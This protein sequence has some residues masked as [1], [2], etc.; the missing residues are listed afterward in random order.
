MQERTRA[1]CPRSKKRRGSKRDADPSPVP[2]QAI[3]SSLFPS[4]PSSFF[5][6]PGN[7]YTVARHTT[8]R[9]T[10]H[11]QYHQEH[12]QEKNR[13][14][15]RT[16]KRADTIVR[17][18][19]VS[20][21]RKLI[22]CV[23]TMTF[24]T[25]RFEPGLE[26]E[27]HVAGRKR[28][29][30]LD[31]WMDELRAAERVVVG[32]KEHVRSASAPVGKEMVEGE[33]PGLEEARG[34]T[35]RGKRKSDGGKVGDVK[36]GVGLVR[37]V[38]S[39]SD[40]AQAVATPLPTTAPPS[41]VAASRVQSPASNTDTPSLG[42]SA[43]AVAETIVGDGFVRSFT[44][45][46]V[47]LSTGAPSPTDMPEIPVD[48]GFPAG[49]DV[50]VLTS[51][52][53]GSFLPAPCVSVGGE[54]KT[55]TCRDF[56][57]G[58]KPSTLFVAPV[59]ADVVP[60]SVEHHG[61]AFAPS[62]SFINGSPP[63]LV[64]SGGP[65][66][67]AGVGTAYAGGQGGNG[68]NT[69]IPPMYDAWVG[70]RDGNGYG[71][72]NANAGAGDFGGND[73]WMDNDAGGPP[74]VRRFP[75]DANNRPDTRTRVQQ[76]ARLFDRPQKGTPRRFIL[77]P[78]KP[79]FRYGNL[80]PSSAPAHSV[81]E[82][83]GQV[84][85]SSV[86][87]RSPERYVNLVIAPSAQHTL[88]PPLIRNDNRFFLFASP[89]EPIRRHA[90]RQT[91]SPARSLPPSCQAPSYAHWVAQSPQAY[92]R[93]AAGA[94]PA[95]TPHPAASWQNAET[96]NGGWGNAGWGNERR[97]GNGGENGGWTDTGY[98]NVGRFQW[99]GIVRGR[100]G[101]VAPYAT[102]AYTPRSRVTQSFRGASPSSE[103]TRGGGFGPTYYGPVDQFVEVPVGRGWN[104]TWGSADAPMG[105]A[106]LSPQSMNTAYAR[107]S[108]PTLPYPVQPQ[109]RAGPTS[110]LDNAVPRP[111]EWRFPMQA[112][113][114]PE[115]GNRS[116]PGLARLEGQVAVPYARPMYVAPP[117]AARQPSPPLFA[118]NSHVVPPRF[119][120][121][122]PPSANHSE[123][124]GQ[125]QPIQQLP[126]F[127]SRPTS[128]QAAATRTTPP[129][130]Q[131]NSPPSQ[132][133]RNEGLVERQSP[134]RPQVPPQQASP[135]VTRVSGL[136]TSNSRVAR[137]AEAYERNVIHG[138][139][140]GTTRKVGRSSAGVSASA[141]ENRSRV[142]GLL[143]LPDRRRNATEGGGQS[144]TVT[145]SSMQSQPVA[146]SVKGRD[147]PAVRTSLSVPDTLP[148][149][150]QPS[151]PAGGRVKEEQGRKR[152][153]GEN[154][155]LSDDFL[156]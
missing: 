22:V 5:F 20:V 121:P 155:K 36:V 156:E 45:Y 80:A 62:G 140:A 28:T 99:D 147:I 48:L 55:A 96:R 114:F 129:V 82:R 43:T 14:I 73:Y 3:K 104:G 15:V 90:P 70:D 9:Y 58:V 40:I 54:K 16:K 53:D 63:S 52:S 123:H 97:G 86:S 79:L 118:Q 98:G 44:S 113:V 31:G 13:A 42:P 124:Q 76:M 1:P 67:M 87:S 111:T 92:S 145:V 154:G 93:V 112:P 153:G 11:I 126:V 77:H 133:S 84:T 78:T 142:E 135:P 128:Y 59:A 88:P 4:L 151:G 12:R 100:S 21:G 56:V 49:R 61:A 143:A 6:S 134:P 132:V 107:P 137:M 17:P 115:Q 29:P 148:S 144:S 95:G 25:P 152:K 120:R 19:V 30:S 131:A 27:W 39:V 75:Q 71:I 136:R 119:A 23:A 105:N 94:V 47:P 24:H 109:P 139:A 141:P 85:P 125:Q 10:S 7:E 101:Y 32:R 108:P 74:L 41:P 146:S 110:R 65:S 130:V 60:P 26:G 50:A 138:E 117:S 91:P 34:W 66:R 127:A 102:S 35:K 103:P 64:P 8:I 2:L 81:D 149:L 106:G 116:D 57:R 150:R 72:G 68:G 83:A 89:S 18:F 69:F 38:K 46:A 122:P 37:D 51:V 33:W